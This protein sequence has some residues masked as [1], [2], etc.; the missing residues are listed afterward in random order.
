MLKNLWKD[1]EFYCSYR[2]EPKK[3]TIIQ[4]PSSLFYAC[5]KYYPEN[6]S[7]D[8]PACPMRLNLIDAQ[9]I[10]EEFSKMIENDEELGIEC[11]YA[12]KEFT[13]KMIKVKVIAIQKE[14][15]SLIFITERR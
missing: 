4:G 10:L 6:R 14:N 8:E 15:L 1:T 12:N 11:N 7:K 9:A 2:H 3:M 5:P 13:Y